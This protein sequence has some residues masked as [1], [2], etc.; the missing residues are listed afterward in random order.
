MISSIKGNITYTINT[1]LMTPIDRCLDKYNQW[2]VSYS[3]DFEF[4][5][6]I[7]AVIYS[8]I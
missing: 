8:S 2:W 4:K 5:N 6:N 7:N 3:D 1:I